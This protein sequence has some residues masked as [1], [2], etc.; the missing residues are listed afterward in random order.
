MKIFI[1]PVESQGQKLIGIRTE[2]FDPACNALIKKIP[3]SH[4]NPGTKS[5]CIPY[6]KNA[7][8]YRMHSPI[9]KMEICMD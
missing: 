8:R 5:W 4:W 9:D 1:F 2:Q 3:G 6:E 7:N